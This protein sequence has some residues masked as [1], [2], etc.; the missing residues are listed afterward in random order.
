[1][2]RIQL[3]DDGRRLVPLQPRTSPTDRVAPVSRGR[4]GEFL[5]GLAQRAT[6]CFERDGYDLALS[7]S[8]LGGHD[9]VRLVWTRRTKDCSGIAFLLELGRSLINESWCA[10]NTRR[11]GTTAMTNAA[12]STTTP[13]TATA[14]TRDASVAPKAATS[15]NAASRRTGAPKASKGAKKGAAKKQA[16]TATTKTSKTTDDRSR[17]G[18]KKQIVIALLERTAGARMAEIAEATGWQNHSIRGF[19][20]GTLGKRMGLKVESIK[21][22]AGERMYKVVGR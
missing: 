15:T 10:E 14:A 20:S 13:T 7:Q 19:I 18:S 8:S 3:R 21:N 1:M 4:R 12:K 9:L 6:G 16:T 11:K 5:L 2:A 17:E 22:N